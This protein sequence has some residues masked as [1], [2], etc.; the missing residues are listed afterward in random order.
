MDHNI[1]LLLWPGRWYLWL[2]AE[3][4]V[5]ISPFNFAAT[6]PL[7][8]AI[9]R[10]TWSPGI[11]ISRPPHLRITQQNHSSA[12]LSPAG[13]YPFPVPNIGFC[14]NQQ[15]H[16]RLTMDCWLRHRNDRP[17]TI[18]NGKKTRKQHFL[19][20][21]PESN[22]SSCSMGGRNDMWRPSWFNL[23]LF[24]SGFLCYFSHPIAPRK[25]AL[26]SES[27]AVIEAMQWW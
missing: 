4:A 23:S 6:E 12:Q 24:R 14:W 15:R 7:H 8:R 20:T 3:K 27:T 16:E 11:R 13:D 19:P 17:D 5:L 2:I 21:K 10:P 18:R 22:M 1:R 9:L 25:V 26:N